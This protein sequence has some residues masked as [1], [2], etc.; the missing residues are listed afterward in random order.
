MNQDERQAIARR[1]LERSSADQTEVRVSS[2]DDALTRFTHGISNQ[3]LASSNVSIAVRAIVDGRTGVAAAND[4]SN[5]SIDA[6][7][8]VRARWLRSHRATKACRRCS[9][10]PSSAPAGSF[11][12]A[13]ALADPLARARVCDAVITHAE[14]SH[15]RCAGYVSSG[16][17]GVTIANSSGALASF[18]GTS[19]AVNVN[20]TATDSTGFAEHYS[21]HFDALDGDDAGARA[22]ELARLSAAP[23]AVDPG[24]WTVILEPPAFGELFTYL[25]AHFSAQNFNDGSSFFSSSSTRVFQ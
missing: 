19:A 3:N 7:L 25:A 14:R 2:S 9:G 10:T 15:Y 21:A 8:H 12:D 24:E 18:E 1:A 16:S 20:V 23:R 5:A 4:L 17:D 13:T 11:V 6:S 22:V